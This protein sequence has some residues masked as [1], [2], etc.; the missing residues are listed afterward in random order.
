MDH[1]NTLDSPAAKDRFSTIFLFL[2][3]IFALAK[4]LGFTITVGVE[5]LNSDFSH[6]YTSGES[7]N[8]GLSPYVNWV[9]HDPSVWDGATTSAHSGSYEPPQVSEVFRLLS[10]MPFSAAKMIW[11]YLSLIWLATA[12]FL[13]MRIGRLTIRTK[14]TLII[15]TFVALFHP[16][17]M[18]LERGQIMSLELV[19]LV[20]GIF[21]IVTRRAQS[22][23]CRSSWRSS[24]QNNRY[25][26]GIFFAMAILIKVH[27]LL[28]IPFLI[29]CRKWRAL[30]GIA[31]AGAA[32]VVLM[33][34]LTGIGFMDEYVNEQL[35]RLAN[36]K[37][38]D[39]SD[40]L[41]SEELPYPRGYKQGKIYKIA[42]D[43]A[44]G[45]S[46]N[47]GKMV[48]HI[49]SGRVWP[50][51]SRFLSPAVYLVLFFP[52]AYMYIRRS[53][54]SPPMTDMQQFALWQIALIMVPLTSPASWTMSLTW[55]LPST[56]ICVY[57]YAF[58]QTK[59]ESLFLALSVFGLVITAIPDKWGGFMLLPREAGRMLLE[60]KYVFAQLILIAGLLFFMNMRI[61]KEGEAAAKTMRHG[62]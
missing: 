41:N 18:Q 62:Q 21:L 42:E 34:P 19:L 8:A 58:L 1:Q 11:I 38:D 28:F 29:L 4:L 5:Y 48:T 36:P 6:Y 45:S 44:V 23:E 24:L 12:I 25:L 37:S 13:A 50:P 40:E 61:S 2:L 49:V 10:L 46:P 35:P 27:S 59:R 56:V 9:N 16:L 43:L 17:Y 15:I 22:R 55:L 32:I 47:V 39:S 31:G 26:P 52:V 3:A 57:W 7:L 60:Y 53:R 20:T 54:A 14:A 33:L 30:A 51:L